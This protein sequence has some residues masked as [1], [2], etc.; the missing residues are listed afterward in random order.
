MPT[1]RKIRECGLD[2]DVRVVG[3]VVWVG[4]LG[5]WMGE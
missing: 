4:G 5:G 3:W 2:A 1:C